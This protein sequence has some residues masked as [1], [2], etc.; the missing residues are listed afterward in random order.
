MFE[1]PV[2]NA[3][4]RYNVAFFKADLKNASTEIQ[5]VKSNVK[6]NPIICGHFQ[7]HYLHGY[8][9]HQLADDLR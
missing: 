4:K 7:F 1:N 8:S 3:F 6:S 2:M 9:H 5:R